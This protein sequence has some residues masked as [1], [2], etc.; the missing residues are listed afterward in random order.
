MVLQ[1]TGDNND[2]LATIAAQVPV[3][4][5]DRAFEI[6]G[7]T[8]LITNNAEAS[9]EMTSHL[10]GQG[11]RQ[12]IYVTEPEAAVPTRVDRLR[13]YTEACSSYGVPPMVFHVD[14]E[15]SESMLHVTNAIQSMAN[16]RPFAVYTAN[17]LIMIELYKPL[18]KLAFGVPREMG[19]ATFDQPD[20]ASLVEPTLTCIRQPVEEMGTLAAN[21]VLERIKGEIETSDPLDEDSPRGE[22]HI[23]PSTLVPGG[24][25][26]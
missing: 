15:N 17:G 5:V 10:L 11:Y 26:L 4:L 19:L 23:I 20:W 18:R 13:G 9:F 3:V 16:E 12:V 1:S 14:R 22:T 24:S 21:V 2:L 6:D 8:N 7:V 25:T